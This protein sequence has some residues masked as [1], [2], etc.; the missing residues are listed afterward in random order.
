LA[1]YGLGQI[2]LQSGALDGAGRHLAR[3]LALDSSRVEYYNDLGWTLAGSGQ[4]AEARRVLALGLARFPEASP[5]PKNVGLEMSEQGD[6]SGAARA[7]DELVRADP[8]Y[9]PARGL[10]AVVRDRLGDPS[11]ARADWTAYLAMAPDSAEQAAFAAQM[12]RLPEPGNSAR[13]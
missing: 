12:T 10:R 3:A 13:L 4:A 9:A 1:N 11:G 7:L 2:D 8:A 5:L 6:C